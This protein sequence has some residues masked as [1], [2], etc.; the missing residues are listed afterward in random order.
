M[1]LDVAHLCH[2]QLALA[3]GVSSFA[4]RPMKGGLWTPYGISKH[5]AE[6]G[7]RRLATETGM[8]VVIIRPP[9]DYLGIPTFSLDTGPIPR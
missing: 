9:L 3:T 5:E 8:E 6:L 1:T 2:Q 4:K 7:L